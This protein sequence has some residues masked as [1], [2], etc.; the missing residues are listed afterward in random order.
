MRLALEMT[1]EYLARLFGVGTQ[2]VHRWESGKS[3]VD[4]SAAILLWLLYDEQVNENKHS[5]RD[6]IRTVR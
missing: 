3:R 2:S 4:R 5:V 1:Q 6:Y